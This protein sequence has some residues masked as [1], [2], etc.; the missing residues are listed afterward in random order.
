MIECCKGRS[1]K[2]V[3]VVN[4]TLNEGV[5]EIE[6]N[7]PNHL[8]AL[9]LEVFIELTEAVR[10]EKTTILRGEGQGNIKSL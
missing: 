7:R 6:L 3:S 8:N 2:R 9:N 1:E 4:T 5:Y 10:E